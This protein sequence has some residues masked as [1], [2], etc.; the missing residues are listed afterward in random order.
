MKSRCYNHNREDYAE[1]GAKGIIVCQ[2]WLDKE[3]GFINFYQWSI[4]NGYQENLSIDR[5]NVYGN[6]EPGN[7]RWTND[8][9][10]ANNKTNTIY[11]TYKDETKTL[12]EWSKL[13]NIN[14]DTLHGRIFTYGMTV[15][16]AF[17]LLN[18]SRE[19]IQKLYVYNGE[20][21]NLYE[22][23]KIL[24][25]RY[26][27]IKARARKYKDDVIEIFK[28]VK[29]VGE[30]G[31]LYKYNNKSYTL[32][33]ISK[34]YNISYDKLKYRVNKKGMTIEEALKDLNTQ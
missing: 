14:Y 17:T 24:N 12:S 25:I 27:V 34:L 8:T 26:S 15:N 29:Y 11:I 23:S 4:E 2:E 10:Q 16:E 19:D 13:L 6:Y 1:Y 28:E 7:C 21:H 31:K 3:N 18:N 32:P 33:E 30:H 9:I 5:I 22:W 20:T